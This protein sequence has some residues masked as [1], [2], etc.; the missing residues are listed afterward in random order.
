VTPEVGAD[1]PSP[2]AAPPETPEAIDVPPPVEAHADGGSVTEAP[3][4]V[5]SP[6]DDD[7]VAR[8]LQAGIRAEEMQ[9]QARA[10]QTIDAQIDRM[11]I[12]QH[13]KSLLRAYP[14]LMNQEIVPI[15]RDQRALAGGV[16]DDTA[17]MDKWLVEGVAQEIEERRHRMAQSARDAVS[18]MPQMQEPAIEKMADRLDQ[19]AE[20]IRLAMDAAETTPVT[21]AEEIAPAIPPRKRSLPVSAPVARDVPGLDG[22]RVEDFRTITLTPEQRIVAR[23]SFGPI[24][25]ANGIVRDLTNDEKELLYALARMRKLRAD[26]LLNE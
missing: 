12:S 6:A 2:P 18:V 20:A 21:M 24:K 19:Q 8:A 7:A 1:V 11:P 23:N 10:P 14:M 22:K 16:E 13:K 5:P 3:A 4:P 9:R 15:A 17:H 26:G 25:D